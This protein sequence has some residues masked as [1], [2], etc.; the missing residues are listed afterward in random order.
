MSLSRVNAGHVAGQ[1]VLI[2]DQ[3]QKNGFEVEEKKVSGTIV[4]NACLMR[5][6]GFCARSTGPQPFDE[7]TRTRDNRLASLNL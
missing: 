6:A 3:R 5:D 1:V 4:H 7:Q 2:A